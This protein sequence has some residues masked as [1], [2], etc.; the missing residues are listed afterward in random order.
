MHMLP[1]TY[2]TARDTALTPPADEQQHYLAPLN[3]EQRVAVE[4]G[5][6]RTRP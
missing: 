3:A 2:P 5:S 1:A 6:M 4:H